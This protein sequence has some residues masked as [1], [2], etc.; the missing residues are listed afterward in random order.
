MR[1][2]SATGKVVVGVKNGAE[3]TQVVPYVIAE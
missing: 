1:K 2:L 3:T